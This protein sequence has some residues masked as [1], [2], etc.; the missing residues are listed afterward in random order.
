M[1]SFSLLLLLWNP[2]S[3]FFIV[4]GFVVPSLSV[5]SLG[6][7]KKLIGTDFGGVCS[8][9]TVQQ[10]SPSSA[11]K[12]SL[13]LSSSSSS[14]TTA[15]SSSKTPPAIEIVEV[16]FDED[17]EDYT[18]GFD[19]DISDNINPTKRVQN[20]IEELRYLVSITSTDSNVVDQAQG[21]FDRMFETY[22]KTDDSTYCPTVEVYNLI[23]E[24]HAYSR[25]VDGAQKAQSILSRMEDPENALIARPNGDSYVNVMDAYAMRKEPQMVH[26][27]LDQQQHRYE[28]T[29]DESVKPT[30]D[31]QNKLIKAYGIIGD[32]DRAESIFRSL[33]VGGASSN[34]VDDDGTAT[35]MKA[36]HK[37]WVQIMKAYV[38]IAA[39]KESQ[40]QQKY[41][42][43]EKVQSLL[44][45]MSHLYETTGDE[46]YRPRTDAYNALIKAV[47]TKH[48]KEGAQEAESIM[49]DMMDRYQKD[50]EVHVKPNDQTFR[51]VMSA[52]QSRFI[53]STAAKVEQLLQIQ[54][55]FLG[56]FDERTY[57]LG[58]TIISKSNDSKKAIRVKRMVDKFKQYLAD[59]GKARLSGS[60]YYSL[61]Y[62]QLRAC[63][64]STDGTAE[65]KF[66]AFQIAV[67]TYKEL[68]RLSEKELGPSSVM[69]FLKACSNL[70]P[71]N[72]KRDVVVKKIFKDCCKKGLV[73]DFVL[74]E[75]SRAASEGL[76]LEVLG[77]FLE[78]DIR[79]PE[80]WSRNL[81]H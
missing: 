4:N 6:S 76:Q 69:M 34:D 18:L 33:L 32:I 81:K 14:S 55:G 58:M 80:D 27:M 52:Y 77:G 62:N 79:I 65:E 72:E 8:A 1:V 60:L 15:S 50:G 25:N 12:S 39:S 30:I 13:S 70:V 2:S 43:I 53:G 71:P 17:D 59:N 42:A 10:S 51:S 21:I 36:D 5:S 56:T 41:D 38:A 68:Q 44:Y 24:A 54:E 75:F 57:Y 22:V 64:Y 73:T 7:N 45:E 29:N 9:N 28:T 20:W 66:E 23:L 78:D 37:S 11:V 40:R 48:G 67:A 74:A 49:F 63:A 46:D 3:T 61:Y 26:A 31:G 19:D 47:G 16:V 35:N